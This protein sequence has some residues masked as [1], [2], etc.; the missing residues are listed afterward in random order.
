[1]GHNKGCVGKCIRQTRIIFPSIV[2]LHNGRM[3]V[4]ERKDLLTIF[5]EGIFMQSWMQLHANTFFILQHSVCLFKGTFVSGVDHDPL[6]KIRNIL[7]QFEHIFVC[8][9]GIRQIHQSFH[10]WCKNRTDLCRLLHPGQFLPVGCIIRPLLHDF[11]N[12]NGF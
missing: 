4:C 9:N 2:H 5:R 11:G 6:I 3:L 7:H 12:R 10:R 8:L 1:M